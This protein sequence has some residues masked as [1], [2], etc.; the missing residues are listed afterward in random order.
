MVLKSAETMENVNLPVPELA[1]PQ[2]FKHFTLGAQSCNIDWDLMSDWAGNTLEALSL[3]YI[4]DDTCISNS[5]HLLI[6]NNSQTLRFLHLHQVDYFYKGPSASVK[7]R[8]TFPNLE[9]LELVSSKASLYNIF[10]SSECP[11]LQRINFVAVD[12]IEESPPSLEC[13]LKFI[14]TAASN[15]TEIIY[16]TLGKPSM[17]P[18]ASTS[19]SSSIMIFS[20]LEKL[21]IGTRAQV[22]GVPLGKWCLEIGEFPNLKSLHRSVGLGGV[23]V[24]VRSRRQCPQIYADALSE[25]KM[26]DLTQSD[27]SHY[28]VEDLKRIGSKKKRKKKKKPAKS[29][30]MSDSR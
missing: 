6:I 28:A 17:R 12:I 19:L 23:S 4:N 11:R 8:I 26:K 5:L 29:E 18:S 14:K 22:D 13:L 3:H 24:W 16:E 10:V 25:I 30:T 9:N 1:T 21:K 2:G 15:L 7:S 27:D 20:K